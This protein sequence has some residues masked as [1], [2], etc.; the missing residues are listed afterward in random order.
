[1]NLKKKSRFSIL[2]IYK[3]L[4]SCL[5]SQIHGGNFQL[6]GHMT[7]LITCNDSSS[8]D[9]STEQKLIFV[10]VQNGFL[11]ALPKVAN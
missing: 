8:P 2:Q 6:I 10:L 5:R 9:F 4:L 11:L 7:S 3:F 1:M